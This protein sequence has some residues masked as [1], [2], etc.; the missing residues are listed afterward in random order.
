MGLA[1]PVPIVEKQEKEEEEQ[2]QSNKDTQQIS[3]CISG[4]H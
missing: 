2:Q 3:V 4:K 1:F